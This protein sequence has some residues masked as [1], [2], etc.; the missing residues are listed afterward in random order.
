M[1]GERAMIKVGFFELINIFSKNVVKIVL[2][3]A[4]IVLPCAT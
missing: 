3:I 1:F 2:N 4:T